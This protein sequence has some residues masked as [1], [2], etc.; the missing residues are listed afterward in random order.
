MTARSLNESVDWNEASAD[1]YQ[2]CVAG[3]LGTTPEF[4]DEWQQRG[5]R[6]RV[7][8]YRQWWVTSQWGLWPS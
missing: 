5:Q 4:V 8:Q 3:F 1:A 6:S 2:M 7:D